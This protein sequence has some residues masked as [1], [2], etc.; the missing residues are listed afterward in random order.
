[1][2]PAAARIGAL[3]AGLLASFIK[4]VM[5]Y[6]RI[7]TYR[8]FYRDPW[9]RALYLYRAIYNFGDYV[10]DGCGFMVYFC[11]Y[12]YCD[13]A[14]WTGYFARESDRSY[15][16]VLYVKSLILKSSVVNQTLS[17]LSDR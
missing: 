13:V 1:M 10:P 14:A 11:D 5:R 9:F 6:Q 12:D 2:P 7:L 16:S 15:V 8:A 17:I 4:R 3:T